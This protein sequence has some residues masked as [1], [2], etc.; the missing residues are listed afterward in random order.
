VQYVSP[1]EITAAWSAGAGERSVRVAVDAAGGDHAP[2]EIVKG[3]LRVAGEQLHVVL[4][5]DG[6]AIRPLLPPGSPHISVVHAPD[7]IGSNEEPARA[8]RDKTQSSIVVGLRLVHAGEADAFVSAGNTGAVVAA[9][10]LY[11]RRIRGVAR[12]AICTIMPCMPTPV[13]FLDVGA[14]AECRPEHLVQ[15][16]VM[17]QAFA[18]EVMGLPEPRVGL[19]SIGEEPSKGTLE[20]IE[21]HRLLAADARV[22]FFGNV[23]GRDI[24]NR[25]VDV[26]V[27]DGFTGNVALKA[28][29]GTGRA[30]LKG[31]RG[32]IDTSVKTKIGGLL[33]R[34]DLYRMKATLDPEEYGGA[35]LVG[36]NAPIVIAHGNSRATAIA[37]AVR[38]GRR[39]VVSALQPTIAR[40]LGK[41][42][43]RPE[44]FV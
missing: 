10:V 38:Q 16:A 43:S 8:A 18:Q 5:G 29:E 31:L 6:A 21:A 19:L 35:F 28:I 24:M 42:L 12:P 26:V 7:A 15:F 14:N 34:N 23:E 39:G 2:G 11:V 1:H 40:E 3:A 36:M 37:N 33:L 13:A 25:V 44:T 41:D 17:G 32:A 22:R 27:T 30:I 4:V 20:V 9:S